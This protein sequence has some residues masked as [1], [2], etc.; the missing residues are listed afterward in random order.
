MTVATTVINQALEK[1]KA[2]LSSA[3]K[4]PPE[5]LG[6]EVDSAQVTMVHL[7][8]YLIDR[9]R[10]A[11]ETDREDIRQV[12]NKTNIALSLIVGV[13]YPATGIKRNLIDEAEKVLGQIEIPFGM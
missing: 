3:K 1:A 2:S 4:Y 10:E 9:L 7:R 11:T 6:S 12:L 8:D 5:K 13:E